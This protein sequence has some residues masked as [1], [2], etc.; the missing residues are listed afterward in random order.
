MQSPNQ[1]AALLTPQ[2]ASRVMLDPRATA[3]EKTQAARIMQAAYVAKT[4]A[5]RA[6]WE[7]ANSPEAIKARVDAM[8][9]AWERELSSKKPNTP[10]RQARHTQKS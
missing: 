2:L 1:P 6:A 3:A 8:L 5:R 7:I 9:E 4:A 10:I